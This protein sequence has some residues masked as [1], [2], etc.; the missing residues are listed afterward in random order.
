MFLVQGGQLFCL[1][2]KLFRRNNNVV[3]LIDG[4]Q[5]L[6]FYAAQTP[7]LWQI[8]GGIKGCKFM[9]GFGGKCKVEMAGMVLDRNRLRGKQVADFPNHGLAAGVLNNKAGN[10][11]TAPGFL[12]TEQQAAALHTQ[13][14]T[15]IDAHMVEPGFGIGRWVV[16][17]HL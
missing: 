4:M 2:E 14:G 8:S 15:G 11:A 17:A 16:E 7:W 9:K 10:V 6:V 13:A 5:I 12:V 3:G 1:F